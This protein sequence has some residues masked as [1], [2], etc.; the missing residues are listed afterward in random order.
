MNKSLPLYSW[1]YW[2]SFWMFPRIHVIS[3]GA[4]H[5]KVWRLRL[6]IHST[7]LPYQCQTHNRCYSTLICCGCTSPYYVT[8]TLV[9]LAFWKFFLISGYL[10]RGKLQCRSV[11]ETEDPFK[12]APTSMPNRYKVFHNSQPLYAHYILWMCIWMNPFHVIAVFDGLA[13]EC[14]QISCILLRDKSKCRS[15]IEAVDPFK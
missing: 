4:N 15:A 11:V 13:F 9:S 6:Y 10:Q 8:A 3:G 1:S 12:W 14:S 5:S 7:G 2:L